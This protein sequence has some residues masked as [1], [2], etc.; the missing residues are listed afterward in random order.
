MNV[1]EYIH[2]DVSIFLSIYITISL[3]VCLFLY[4]YITGVYIHISNLLKN[5][6]HLPSPISDTTFTTA[7]VPKEN[8]KTK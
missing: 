6:K 4:K 5:F 2:I 1:C 8:I 7:H 3:F